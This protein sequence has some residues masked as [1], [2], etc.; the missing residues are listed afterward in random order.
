MRLLRPIRLLHVRRRPSAIGAVRLIL[1]LL[2]LS[3]ILLLRLRWLPAV[4]EL[5]AVQVDNETSNLLNDAI[6]DYLKQNDLNYTDLVSLETDSAGAV[7]A[8]QMNMPMV[9]R[10]KSR[11]LEN[12][13]RR[14]PD[15]AE[16]S[17]GIPV[18]SVLLPALFSGRGGCLPVRVSAMQGSNA[19]FVSS[20]S[21]AGINQTLHRIDLEVRVDL[22]LMTPAGE[23]QLTVQTTVPVAQTVLVGP[24]PNFYQT[25]E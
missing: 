11:I 16:R 19:E 6:D 3:G 15:L 20:F 23:Q 8:L 21:D 2:L 10:V 22:L 1:F 12:V 18:G 4:R 7:T 24:V 5:A 14:M 9:S 17:I 25:G 13:S